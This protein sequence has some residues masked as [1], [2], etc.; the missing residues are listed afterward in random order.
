MSAIADNYKG[1]QRKASKMRKGGAKDELIAG[2]AAFQRAVDRIAAS[3]GLE[4]TSNFEKV[5]H[6]LP[7]NLHYGPSIVKDNPGSGFDPSTEPVPDTDGERRLEPTS[8]ALLN[9][10]NTY[11]QGFD[12]S[13]DGAL[14]P[15]RWQQLAECLLTAQA[16]YENATNLVNGIAVN[17]EQWVGTPGSDTYAKK[18]LKQWPGLETARQRFQERIGPLAGGGPGLSAHHDFT[19]A[20]HA[21]YQQ[22]IR[23]GYS[24]QSL[25]HFCN[26]HTYRYFDKAQIKLQNTFFRPGTDQGGV[27]QQAAAAMAAVEAEISRLNA[28]E[29]DW[30]ETLGED[31]HTFTHNNMTICILYRDDQWNAGN[32]I[33][34]AI[35]I[36]MMVPEGGGYE[37]YDYAT[38]TAL[39]LP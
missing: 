24:V 5:L 1:C 8:E 9:F 37:N 11:R 23:I 36:V 2:L 22:H 35:D 4:D 7:L 3:A 28:E 39:N 29:T 33:D 15:E 14:S 38:L 18:G 16:A 12:E 26:R 27:V 17:M 32:I 20:H 31:G 19:L 13:E 6:N 10:Y 21:G 34:E 30:I 25:Q